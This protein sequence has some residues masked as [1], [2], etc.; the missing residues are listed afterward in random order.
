MAVACLNDPLRKKLLQVLELEDIRFE[1]DY[2]P[3]AQRSMEFG[4]RLVELAESKFKIRNTDDW[5]SILF[6]NNIPVG[7]IRFKEE[8]FSDAKLIENG[9][10]IDVNHKEQGKVRMTGGLA[11]FS[12]SNLEI[13][14]NLGGLGEHTEEI[15][16][17]YGFTEVQ[18]NAFRDDGIIK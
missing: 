8:L 12:K 16:E 14:H 7:P 6:S 5:L 9:F 15:L 17:E 13:K 4:Y 1:M 10:L 3:R 18:R 2:D 11:R